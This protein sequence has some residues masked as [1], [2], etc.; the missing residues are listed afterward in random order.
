MSSPPVLQRP[1]MPPPLEERVGTWL[2][3][4]GETLA[5][6]ESCT[7]GLLGHRLT[8][9]P[10]ASEYFLG[11]VVAYSYEAKE[12]V[13]HVRHETLYT[14]GAVSRET[15]LEMAQGIRQ[16]L[17]SDL[18]VAV[19][20]IAGPGGGLPG[21]PVGLTWVAVSSRAGEWSERHEFHGDR[22]EIKAQAAEAALDLLMRALEG[23]TQG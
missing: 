1:M 13:L 10:G 23:K 8:N 7:G 16:V 5:I 12:R 14:H 21:K 19:T 17:S 20:G 11:S 9:V 4:K 22:A 2:R 3:Q 15:V 18:G 6:A